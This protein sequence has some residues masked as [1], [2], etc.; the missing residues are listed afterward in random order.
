MF[1][2]SSS[3]IVERT[4]LLTPGAVF[5]EDSGTAVKQL[6]A[7]V[8]RTT[9]LG[10]CEL[11]LPPNQ[12]SLRSD[13]AHGVNQQGASVVG[14]LIECQL[15]SLEPSQWKEAVRNVTLHL[16]K[17]ALEIYTSLTGAEAGGPSVVMPIRKA[18]VLVRCLEFAYRDSTTAVESISAFGFENVVG[19]AGEVERLCTKQVSGM[20][21]YFIN[22]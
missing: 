8:D 1:P 18:R 7:L 22:I 12:I 6:V 20:S 2:Y 5:G 3:G 11:F 17:D 9:Y 19:A 13:T 4:S 16:L 14:A 21:C 10:A 15:S